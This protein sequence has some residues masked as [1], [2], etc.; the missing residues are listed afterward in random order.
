MFDHPRCISDSD[1]DAA[2]PPYTDNHEYTSHCT[3]VPAYQAVY[4]GF[5]INVGDNRYPFTSR[6]NYTQQHWVT[7][8]RGMVAQGFVEGSV[9]GWMALEE[10]AMWMNNASH[11][12]DIGFF[13]TLSQ[14]RM[15][16]V[17]YLVHGR[18][19]RPPV[20]RG[21]PGLVA[22][23]L[24]CDLGTIGSC[25]AAHCP[26][27]TPSQCCNVSNVLVNAW[28]NQ[29]AS[30][31]ALV[32]A[33]HGLLPITVA[34]DFVLPPALLPMKAMVAQSMSKSGH[35]TSIPLRKRFTTSSGGTTAEL[36]YRMQGLSAVVFEVV[37]SHTAK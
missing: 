9:M 33:N 3:S 18:L 34:V 35:T 12:A 6:A 30:A 7:M 32:M 21:V 37:A 15:V 8:Q 36:V 17:Q 1:D 23:T 4:G 27:P 26:E 22:T 11:A 14:L 20:L 24:V 13:R 10:L 5:A 16:A 29:N 19:W 31:L 25:S 28:V 2:W